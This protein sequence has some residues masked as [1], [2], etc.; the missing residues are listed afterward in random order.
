MI[1]FYNIMSNGNFYEN[2]LI[3][4]NDNTE[5]FF[6]PQNSQQ[7]IAEDFCDLNVNSPNL[8]AQNDQN[9]DILMENFDK[10]VIETQNEIKELYHKYLFDEIIIRLD[11]KFLNVNFKYNF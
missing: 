7:E 11:H 3:N 4:V 8:T 5:P 1:R 2:G 6:T 9:G 10:I